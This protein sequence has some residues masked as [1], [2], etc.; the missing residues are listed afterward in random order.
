MRGQGVRVEGYRGEAT[1]RNPIAIV[2]WVFVSS[3]CMVSS[4][5]FTSTDDEPDRFV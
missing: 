2:S 1:V 4:T 3:A 5:G